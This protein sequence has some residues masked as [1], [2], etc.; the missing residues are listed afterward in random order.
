MSWF[1]NRTM[2][3]MALAGVAFGVLFLAVGVWLTLSEQRLPLTV[4]SFLDL[5]RT[6]PMLVMLD[7]APLLFGLI[8]GLIGSQ[9]GLLRVIERSKQEWELIF[10]SI[11]DPILVA[12]ENGRILRCNHALV[13]RLNTNY[14]NVI[15]QTI[16]EIFRLPE[17]SFG[18]TLHAYN[19]LGRVYDVS[20]FPLRELE[21]NNRKL[22]VLHDITDRKQAQSSLE[23]TES[24]LRALLDLLPDAVVII[25]PNDSEGLWP[26]LDCNEATCKMNG[27]RR[28]ELVGHSVD[29]LNGTVGT[30]A[31][32]EEY[33][34][35]LRQAGSFHLETFHRHKNGSVFPVEVSTTLLNIGGHERVV[36]IDRDITSRKEAEAAILQQ[37]QYFEAVVNNSPVA[38]VV[39]D[40]N[41]N[42]I[43]SNP[44]FENLFQ[45]SEEAILGRNI[46]RL[47]TTPELHEEAIRYT[48]EVMTKSVHG[49][50]K[51]ARKDGSL[52]DVEI[53]GVPVFVKDERIGAL[54]IYHDI[55]DLVRARQAAED[56][57]R[58]KSEFLANMSH[59]IR[60]PMN[61]VIGMLELALDT[62]L[63]AEQQDY[64][65]T[66]LHSAESLLV[67]IN[68]I[69][70]FS[71]IE[72]GRLDLE[73]IDFELRTTIE[74]VGYALAKRAEE[75]G[76]E[77]VCLIHP[78]LT[79]DLNGDPAR[80]RQVLVN[81]VGNA[82]KFT[83]HG[84]IIIRAEHT[85]EDEK[86][87]NITFSV[88][89]TGIGIPFERQAAIF[90]RFTQADGSTTRK[91][92]GTGLG[93][94]IS[95]QLV[96]AMG[97]T[98][99]V[100]SIPGQG[101][102]FWF[103]I[104]FEKRPHKVK[105]TT[106][107]LMPQTVNL[108][109]A[110]VLV[111]DDNATNRTVLTHMA[112]GFG[113]LVDA[114]ASGA[115][116][117]EVLRHAVRTGDPFNIVLL[118]MQMPG[119]DG[120]QT[121]QAIRSDPALNGARIIILTSMGKRGDAARLEALGC[122]AYLLK[123]V[124]Q[125]MLKEV[126]MS[127]VSQTERAPAAL[128]TRH[129]ISEQK[130]QD[131]RILLAEDNPINQ[132]L[133]V[134]LLQK[135]G[136]SVDAVESGTHAVEK[137]K[138]GGYNIILMDV[139]MAEM[140]GLEATGVIRAWESEHGIHTPII[141]MTAHALSG[142]RERCIEAG[143]DDYLSKPLQPK[144][145]FSMLE[146]WSQHDEESVAAPDSVPAHAGVTEYTA[147]QNPAFDDDGLFGEEVSESEPS[148]KDRPVVERI[149][150]SNT[151]PMDLSDA[152]YH[153]DGDRPFMLE[154]FAQFLNG[155][156][157]RVAELRTA[158]GQNNANHLSRTA[159]NLKGTCLN[160]GTEPLAV[161][162]ARLEELGRQETIQDAGILVEQMQEEAT[163]LQ[164]FTK[165]LS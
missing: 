107:R 73:Y 86:T 20:V 16:A 9:R 23:Q 151:P 99:G 34:G 50:G 164:E 7:L 11:S 143:M 132:K 13:V 88:E 84:E 153:F 79:S 21:Q 103:S 92:G 53:F 59:E 125:Q 95:K 52:V 138:Q 147:M 106:A 24:L 54:A 58:T 38:I 46:D 47:I 126:L 141:A 51:R 139:Q 158:L 3:S 28:E 155:L 2:Y 109:S 64:L 75:K 33:L 27:Y 39:L 19:W 68:D 74:D 110:R 105:P 60:T 70:D 25:D 120:E 26:I 113:C 146:R 136:Y 10:D 111:I 80:L 35:H 165:E 119:M 14:R 148:A 134:T 97:G 87:V 5:H 94:T 63:T 62:P 37:K 66:S 101:S 118:D 145:F 159:H 114:V 69:L 104:R 93:L 41:E 91:Y 129:Q 108:H 32:R 76:L 163:R 65:Q 117:V 29:V 8:G 56:A 112:Q 135:A 4:W 85:E 98:I 40:S 121:A 81:L 144:V 128:V 133:A 96:E 61:G 160:F 140:D 162:A 42:I 137:V 48:H 131:L 123:P 127:V 22:I 15:G 44:A 77:L 116:G 149:D 45:Y 72:A 12:D 36:G 150:F 31:E 156:P 18:D 67:L 82:I 122:S 43:S 71:K 124:K 49:I 6:E 30:R 115:K 100:R 1:K 55:S 142:D 102:T 161:L 83:H 157:A 78:D 89:D 57:S 130:R 17:A 154:M 90:E 152:L